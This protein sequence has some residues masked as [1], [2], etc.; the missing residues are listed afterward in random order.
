MLVENIHWFD[1]DDPYNSSEDLPVGRFDLGETDDDGLTEI[2]NPYYDVG[3]RTYEITPAPKIK[4]PSN[5]IVALKV[6][7]GGTAPSAEVVVVNGMAELQQG[8][9]M[10]EYATVPLYRFVDATMV[11]DFRVGPICPMWEFADTGL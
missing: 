8:Q 6:A 4:I 2:R 3:C 5:G 9:A 1:A 10:L 7:A 11:C